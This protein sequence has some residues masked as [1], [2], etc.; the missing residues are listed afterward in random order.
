MRARPMFVAFARPYAPV[1]TNVMRSCAHVAKPTTSSDTRALPRRRAARAPGVDGPGGLGPERR[2]PEERAAVAVELDEA[3]RA[4]R[5]PRVGREDHRLEGAPRRRRGR[6]AAAAPVLVPSLAAPDHPSTRPDAAKRDRL[7]RAPV[8][9]DRGARRAPRRLRRRR[10]PLDEPRRE[11]LAAPVDVHLEV[12]AA[13]RTSAPADRAARR[14]DGLVGAASGP[15]AAEPAASRRSQPLAP[16]PPARAPGAAAEGA[17]ELRRRE[18]AVRLE[19][20][21]RRR[22]EHRPRELL[23][24]RLHEG[25]H[26]Q[27][28][29]A[30]VGPAHG[31][32]P[33]H[34]AARPRRD[35][36]CRASRRRRAPGGT[37]VGSRYVKSS[38]ARDAL[39][40]VASRPPPPSVAHVADA[41]PAPRRS[42]PRR[43]RRRS[44][45]ARWR[46]ADRAPACRR[47]SPGPAPPARTS[48]G[49]ARPRRARAAASRGRAWGP[50]RR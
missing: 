8:R 29:G 20:R 23:A 3:R 18:L 34:Q 10:G 4:R 6:S 2:V 50:R 26:R 12:R 30:G 36:R 27:R 19:A 22:A 1:G 44:M 7:E 31:Q 32:R 13:R 17:G 5:R 41:Q 35:R 25:R 43:P 38:S 48:D 47:A 39:T 42:S 14:H 11:A 33:R 15:S 21:E 28:P 46:A 37:R 40:A 24:S 9:V 16:A 45:P 49:R